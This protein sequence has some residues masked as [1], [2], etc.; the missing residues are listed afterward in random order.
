MFSK[1]RAAAVA[2]ALAPLSV[3]AALVE[4]APDPIADTTI[5]FGEGFSD[6]ASNA[7]GENLSVGQSADGVTRRALIRFDLS[8][9]TPGSIIESARLSLFQ[10][11]SRATYDVALHR[12]LAA[13]GEGTSNGGSAGQSATVTPGDATWI[14]ARW[15]SASDPNIRWTNAGGDFAS[16][17]SATIV[18]GAA[19]TSYEWETTAMVADVQAWVNLPAS[20]HGWILIGEESTNQ[21]AKLFSSRQSGVAPTLV[22]QISPIPEPEVYAMM[23]CGVGLIGFALRNRQRKMHFGRLCL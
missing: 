14:S 21:N 19:G 10:S 17:A 7:L 11:R 9:I 18:V 1:V 8:A 4:I 6:Q 5:Y 3:H 13:W 15:E 16:P 20:N 22:L 12:I 2:L 23:I